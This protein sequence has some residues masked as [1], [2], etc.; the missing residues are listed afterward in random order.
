[1]NTVTALTTFFLANFL[2]FQ[3]LT[4][5]AKADGRTE[6]FNSNFMSI[7]QPFI[8]AERKSRIS[9]DQ[10][11]FERNALKASVNDHWKQDGN[12][13]SFDGN[14]PSI[15]TIKQ[16]TDFELAFDWKISLRGDFVVLLK[17]VPGPRFWDY[18][19]GPPETSK[20]GSGGLFLNKR[21]SPNPIQPADLTS[22]N[23]NTSRIRMRGDRVT[24][25]LNDKKVVDGVPLE[26]SWDRRK[27]IPINGPIGLQARGMPF[28]VRNM[29]IQSLE[30]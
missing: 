18:S 5:I 6:T 15:E 28:Q 26:N 12:L 23:W 14:G 27:P 7:W 29:T 30:P 13:I 20:K 10:L 22:G 19:K 1:M 21:F 9:S 16:Y 4:P 3:D 25:W 2:F 24:V 8:D 17:G 11:E